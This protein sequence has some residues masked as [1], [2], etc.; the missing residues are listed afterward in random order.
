MGKE[1]I[2]GRVIQVLM[3]LIA[4]V[5]MYLGGFEFL[6]ASIIF[7]GLG[8]FYEFIIMIKFYGGKEKITRNDA[9][10]IKL[11][12]GLFWVHN[13]IGFRKKYKNTIYDFKSVGQLPLFVAYL[14]MDVYV[15]V[16]WISFVNFFYVGL[17]L[18]LIPI[19]FNGLSFFW[20]TYRIK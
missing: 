15:I 5:V 9:F 19:I 16:A 13:L 11:K 3:I 7:Y 10:A 1:D 2:F 4:L 8:S 12:N 17:I 6:I 14:I 18:Y 20:N